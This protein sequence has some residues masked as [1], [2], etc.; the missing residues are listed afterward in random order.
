MQISEGG[1]KAPDDNE[2]KIRLAWKRSET[3][4]LNAECRRL[5]DEAIEYD[6]ELDLREVV[7]LAF[8]AGYQA[9]KPT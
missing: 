9:A 2:Q 1:L 6:Y 3:S 8:K 7:R 5:C 4:E